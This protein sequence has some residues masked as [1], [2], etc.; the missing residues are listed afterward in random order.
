MT[1][2]KKD[3]TIRWTAIILGSLAIAFF[4]LIF[5][6]ETLTE[7]N[8]TG[9]I[10][11]VPELVPTFLFIGTSIVGFFISLLY[12]NYSKF[13]GTLM[14][15]GSIAQAVYLLVRGGLSDADAALIY[16]LPFFIPGLLFY[17]KKENEN[18]LK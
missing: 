1:G 9:E 10:S 11:F 12:S 13:G 3:K 2:S 16:M 15:L 14:M 4:L 6:G 17:L 7:Y 5:I 8:Q 18:D